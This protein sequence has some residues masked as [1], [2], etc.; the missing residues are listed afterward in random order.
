[1]HALVA[2]H[3][4]ASGRL[5]R[6]DKGHFTDITIAAGLWNL[7]Y[8]PGAIASDLDHDGRTDLFVAN[9]YLE[10]LPLHAPE[11]RDPPR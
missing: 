10:G 3:R 1:M 4:P 6:N 7:G 5:Y 2:Q 9:D 11:E 8:G